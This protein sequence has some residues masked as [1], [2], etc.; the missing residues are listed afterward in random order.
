MVY[1][2]KEHFPMG[3]YNKLKTKKFGLYKIVKRHNYRN[4]YKLSFILN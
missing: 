3:T 4:A 1:L 2:R